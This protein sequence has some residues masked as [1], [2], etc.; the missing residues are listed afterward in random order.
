MRRPVIAIP[1][2]IVKRSMPAINEA[3][4]GR[5]LPDGDDVAERHVLPVDLEIGDAVLEEHRYRVGDGRDRETGGTGL[6]LAITD[7]ASNAD[8][9]GLIIEMELPM[10]RTDDEEEG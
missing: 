2:G 4:S 5:S 7:C 1:G 3:A 10:R 9:G 8:D 6:R